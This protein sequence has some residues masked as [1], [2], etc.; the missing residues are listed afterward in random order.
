M[1]KPIARI[2]T[3][4][5]EGAIPS[6]VRWPAMVWVGVPKIIWRIA[7]NDAVFAQKVTA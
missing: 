3:L 6:L 5:K 7:S 1:L 4:N 2:T